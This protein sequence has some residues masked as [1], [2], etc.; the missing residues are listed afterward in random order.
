MDA[1]TEK[2]HQKFTT[3]QLSPASWNPG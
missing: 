1:L 2:G 3:I